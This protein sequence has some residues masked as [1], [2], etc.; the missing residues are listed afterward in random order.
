MPKVF[1][2][3]HA[4]PAVT[5]VV[6]GRSDPPLS[7]AGRITAARLHLSV[8]IAYTSPLRRACE[9]AAQL[10][11]PMTIL[12]DLAEISYGEWDG[13]TWQEIE[14]SHPELAA[15]KHRD[16]RG[17]TPS[18]GE[19]WSAFATRVARALDRVRAGP[20]PAAIVAHAAVNAE[21]ARLLSGVDPMTFQQEYCGVALYDF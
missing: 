7:E 16:W 20:F 2:V 1:L 4:E 10:G 9:T 18:G 3:R 19:E 5:G 15:R 8:A 13:R 21:I 11:V 17:V 14:Q 12:D 6:L